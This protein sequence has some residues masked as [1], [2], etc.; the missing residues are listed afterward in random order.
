MNK[1]VKLI[2]FLFVPM[3]VFAQLVRVEPIDIKVNYSQ[4]MHLIFP[5]YIKY[6]SSVSELVAVDNPESVPF[7]LRIKANEKDFNETT[8]LTVATADGKFYDFSVSYQENLSRTN[9]FLLN[10]FDLRPENIGL[11]ERTETH[12]I[13]DEGIKY[14]DVGD[15][16]VTANIAK[17]TR[18]ILRVKTDEPLEIKTNI[19]VVTDDD[20]FFTY[21]AYYSE[22]PT[23]SYYASSTLKKQ[24]E[25]VILKDND[26]TDAQRKKVLEQVNSYK[27]YLFSLGEKKEGILFSIHNIFIHNRFIFFR[28]EVQ[29]TTSIPYNVEYTKFT[30]IDRKKNKLTA[31]QEIEQFPVFLENYQETVLPKQKNAFTIGFETFTIP[32]DKILR[33]ELNERNGGRHIHFNVSNKDIVNGQVL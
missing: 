10:N 9:L 23:T 14:I 17:N 16:P 6:F 4:T 2:V 26:F 22:S 27:R 25:Q 13:F 32:D 12:I 29:N 30:I 19:S 18:N 31:T 11:N 28:C 5:S 8:N 24:D 3:I 21:D 33:I 1:L 15:L 7:L 20:R